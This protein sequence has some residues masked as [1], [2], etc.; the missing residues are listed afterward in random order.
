MPQMCSPR[1]TRSRSPRADL[2]GRVLER[3]PERNRSSLNVTI[4]GMTRGVPGGV[5]VACGHV[6]ERVG[7]RFL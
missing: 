1:N 2:I 5:P 3:D 4:Q 7:A 6:F